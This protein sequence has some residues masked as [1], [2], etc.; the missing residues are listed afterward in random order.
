MRTLVGRQLQSD[1][2]RKCFE[3]GRSRVAPLRAYCEVRARLA[4][5]KLSWAPHPNRISSA[6]LAGG[7]STEWAL[8][9]QVNL[10]DPTGCYATPYL[11][12]IFG[13]YRRRSRLSRFG[14]RGQN[15]TRVRC[16][17]TCASLN[18]SVEPW[19]LQTEP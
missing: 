2:F 3:D 10:R 18:F 13:A 5:G 6:V 9:A 4:P 14:D 17:A 12:G 8:R 19:K 15:V 16:P 11:G 7:A 1:L